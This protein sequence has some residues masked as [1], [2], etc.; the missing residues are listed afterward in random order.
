MTQTST[1]QR[2][3]NYQ[4]QNTFII[5]MK[6]A[7]TKWNGLTPKQLEAVERALNSEA[8]VINLEDVPENIKSILNYQGENSFVKDIASKFRKYG[9]LTDKQI[10]AATKQIT[11]EE[12]KERTVR[13][14]W[15]TPGETIV[16]GRK[17][18][19]QLKETY[20]L[21]FNPTLLDI[22]KLLGV[23]PKAVKFAGKMTIKRGKVCVSCM[24][25]LTD[26][27]S[28][29][30]GMGKICAAHFKVP[31]IKDVSEATRFRE[32]YLKRVEEIGEMEFWIPRK[33]IKKWNGSTEKVIKMF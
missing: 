21:E 2:V 6:D 29:L 24:K 10:D 16:I 27:F 33:Q 12:D 20:G 8:K 11:K 31:Y 23:S 15:P 32:D 26:E 9:T 4:G 1:I 18:G 28:M 7:L 25:D 14:N 5:K 17:I 13:M 19:Q 3:S 22:T 30:T